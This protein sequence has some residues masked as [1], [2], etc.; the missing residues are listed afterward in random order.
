MANSAPGLFF[1][2]LLST[3]LADKELAPQYV[4]LVDRNPFIQTAA[5]QLNENRPFPPYFFSR[6]SFLDVR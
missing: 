2:Q 5:I 3:L 4:V 1:S 6:G